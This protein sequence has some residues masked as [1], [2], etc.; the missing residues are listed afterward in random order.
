M[1]E[2]GLGIE[3]GASGSSFRCATDCI[4]PPG[5]ETLLAHLSHRLMVSYCHQ[6]MSGVR[7]ASCVVRRQQLLQT[8]SPLKRLSLGP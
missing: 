3:P 4:M 1:Y 8:T 7:R 6:P 5:Y 2:T